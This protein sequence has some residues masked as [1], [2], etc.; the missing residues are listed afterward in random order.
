M[1]CRRRPDCSGKSSSEDW[2]KF[3]KENG[4]DFLSEEFEQ[5]TSELREEELDGIDGC[6]INDLGGNATISHH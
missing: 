2:L 3:V 4:F 1:R 6:D 5:V